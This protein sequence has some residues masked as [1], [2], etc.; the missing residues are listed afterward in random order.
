MPRLV[1]RAPLK[2]RIKAF[3]DPEEFLFW[4]SEQIHDDTFEELLKEWATSI[5]VG[6]NILF[7]IARGASTA[8][9]SSG[10]DDVFG[11]GDEGVSGS[12]LISWIAAFIV[13]SLTILCC[14]NAVYTFARKRHYRLFEQSVHVAPATPSAHRVLVNDS[15]A[16]SSP[17]RFLRSVID[18]TVAAAIAP[19][20]NTPD[21]EREVWELRV[22][23]P[24]PLNLTIFTLFSPGHL[25][26]YYSLL[27]PAAK[28][29]RPSLTVLTAIAFGALLSLQLSMLKSS[30]TQ[31][32]KDAALVHGEVMNEYD[33]KFVRPALQRP[34]RDVGIQTQSSSPTTSRSD[35]MSTREVDVYPP[36]TILKREFRTNPNPNYATYYD[37]STKNSGSDA[38]EPSTH[39]LKLLRRQSSNFTPTSHTNDATPSL[40]T[41]MTGTT[42]PGMTQT[43]FS[44]PLKPHHERV[45]SRTSHTIASDGGNMGV[46]SH[47]A[48]PMRKH[49]IGNGSALSGSGVGRIRDKEDVR[50]RMSTTGRLTHFFLQH[51]H[52]PSI[53]AALAK[54]KTM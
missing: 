35:G 54:M 16:A 47:A 1:R 17:L 52:L 2:D 24:T 22:W 29:Q 48:S 45:R 26:L 13:Q 40:S 15:P 21:A 4:L 9:T 10:L 43:D 36:T 46:Y 7:I 44:S 8:S 33:T 50:K 3:L 6:L 14:I 37:P 53:K 27:P 30:F 51:S 32:A 18:T 5:G 49:S 34:V 42:T 28:D 38:E 11:E 39:G 31:Q 12:G 19:K 25:L 20:D 23:D 41:A